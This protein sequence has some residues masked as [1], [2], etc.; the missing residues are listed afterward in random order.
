MK[1]GVGGIKGL[2][3]LLS[4]FLSL[5]LFLFFFFLRRPTWYSTWQKP[6]CIWLDSGEEDTAGC[7]QAVLE[8]VETDAAGKFINTDTQL[9]QRGL[10]FSSCSE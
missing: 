7:E 8:C 4:F 6:G 5:F 2:L 10:V 3:L 9:Q 1:H